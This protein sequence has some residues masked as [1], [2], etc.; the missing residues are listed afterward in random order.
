MKETEDPLTGAH[1]YE[2]P[3]TGEDENNLGVTQKNNRADYYINK[4][5]KTWAKII[6]DQIITKI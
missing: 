6:R 4:R 2:K 1:I 5:E 3:D